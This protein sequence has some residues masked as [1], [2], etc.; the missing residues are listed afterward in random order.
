MIFVT[1]HDAEKLNLP[2]K[3]EVTVT[4]FYSVSL[5]LFVF[6]LRSHFLLCFDINEKPEK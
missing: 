4:H 3:L 1:M 5:L 2:T 6:Q